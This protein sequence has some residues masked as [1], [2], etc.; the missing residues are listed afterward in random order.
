MRR[1]WNK[2]KVNYKDCYEF[3]DN[4]RNGDEKY[5]HWFPSILAFRDDNFLGKIE[6]AKRFHDVE[7]WIKRLEG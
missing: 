7:S 5:V 3:F 2:L 4:M 1:V 6:G